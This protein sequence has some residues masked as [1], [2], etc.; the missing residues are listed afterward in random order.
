MIS[1]ANWNLTPLLADKWIAIQCQERRLPLQ[2]LKRDSMAT[3]L[4]LQQ[5]QVTFDAI[6]ILPSLHSETK[7]IYAHLLK[8]VPRDDRL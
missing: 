5:D 4:D 1:F 8:A 3:K 7:G 6:H 2:K